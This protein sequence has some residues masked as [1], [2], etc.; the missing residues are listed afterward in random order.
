MVSFEQVRAAVLT[1]S[2]PS[3][4][5]RECAGALRAERL[6]EL[7]PG[8]MTTL[9]ALRDFSI[10]Q[11]T[12]RA[13]GIDTLGLSVA[14]DALRRLDGAGE[15]ML[16]HFSGGG[17]VFTVITHAGRILACIRVVRAA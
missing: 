10:R 9:E 7:G 11:R 12:A 14:L 1:E 4:S 2:A 17:R 15:V 3:R 5:L 8:R 16:F 13:A 6:V